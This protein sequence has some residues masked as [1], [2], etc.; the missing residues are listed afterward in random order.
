MKLNLK[1]TIIFLLI[2]LGLVFRVYKWSK[3]N[4][5][6]GDEGIQLI[7]A[8]DILSGDYITLTGEVSSIDK[9][10]KFIL[11]NSPLGIYFQAFLYLISF[12]S[13]KLYSFAYIILNII[14]II[15]IYKAIKLIS[16]EKNAVI[17]LFLLLF[18][19]FMLNASVW[20]SQPVNSLFFESIAIY[21][22]A[23]YIKNKNERY[24]LWGSIMTI[25]ATQMYPP[26][27]LLLVPKLIMGG[28]IFAKK[29]KNKTNFLANMM[30]AITIIYIPYFLMELKY[31]WINTNSLLNFF[32]NLNKTTLNTVTTN[33]ISHID[34]ISSLNKKLVTYYSYGFY[35]KEI[36]IYIYLLLISI[37]TFYRSK[38]SE[39]KKYL[40]SLLLMSFP[41]ISLYLLFSKPTVSAQRAYIDIVFP[42]LTI[43][44]ALMHDKI[45]K[46]ITTLFLIIYISVTVLP[47]FDY[48]FQKNTNIVTLDNIEQTTNYILEDT[49]NKNLKNPFIHVA[50][51]GDKWGWDG[52]I[53][54]YLL[55]NKL[56]KNLVSINFYTSKAKIN[57]PYILDGYIY[58]ICHNYDEKFCLE[59]WKIVASSYYYDKYFTSIEKKN[60]VG[61]NTIFT[62]KTE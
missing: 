4:M 16:K 26:M 50:S 41:V 34:K 36:Y 9:D 55:E 11:H 44:I 21:L 38:K 52:S 58:L 49:K 47:M 17:A 31:N 53:Y 40:F 5:Y 8:E 54:W 60:K 61:N 37:A 25:I 3:F 48:F 19:P 10:G 29:I 2:I 30:I 62:I 18:S 22:V 59:D 12:K 43:F 42:F 23:Y 39:T 28:Y 13:A 20:T 6:A 32:K 33:T 56:D 51:K 24:F 57:S 35:N 14:S 46:N 15:S 7:Y 27:Y 45:S 1:K